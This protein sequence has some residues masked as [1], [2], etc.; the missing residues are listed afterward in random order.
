MALSE[1]V[2][3]WTNDGWVSSAVEDKMKKV[4]WIAPYIAAIFLCLS[5]PVSAP[6]QDSRGLVVKSERMALVIGNGAYQTAP[7]KNPVNDA[8][9]LSKVLS[10]MGFK[11]SLHKNVDK[12]TMEESIRNF[13]RQL[14]SGGVGLFYFAGHG[15]QVE[16]QNYLIPVN[17]KIESESDIKYE[18]VD[19]G[20][21]LGKMEDAGNQLNI[22]IL[23]ACRN[24]PFSRSFRNAAAGLA[25]MDAPTGSLIAYSTAPG[26]VAADG[27][28]RN[29]IF[30]K[31][32]IKHLAAPNLTVEQVLKKVRIDVAAETNQ[33]QIPWESSSLMGEF[34]FSAVQAAPVLTLPG[35]GRFDGAWTIAIKCSD[36]TEGKT[37]ARGYAFQFSAEVKDGVLLG[38]HKA[39]GAPGSLTLVGKIQADGA[40][41]LKANGVTDEPEFSI[42]NISKGTPYGYRIKA[43]FEDSRGT[44]SRVDGRACDFSFAKK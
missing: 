32:L 34:Y 19:A 13:G 12:R 4:K 14:K 5:L 37:V 15:M 11:V 2:A 30:T 44:G 25:R 33:R 16:G 40:A 29:G 43:R 39:K 41:E 22:V 42:N 3:R 1:F 28:E 21:V 7:L 17:A 24:N 26:A 35:A 20:M 31:H 9:D 36:H 6:P 8:E 18:A 23:D 27:A 10:S 38:Q